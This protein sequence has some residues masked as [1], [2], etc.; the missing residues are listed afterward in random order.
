MNANKHANASEIVVEVR[1]NKGSL[2]VSVVDD[3]VGF[4]LKSAKGKGLGIHI[5]QSRARSIG[6]R[7]VLKSS[8]SGGACVMCLLPLVSKNQPDTSGGNLA[9]SVLKHPPQAHNLPIH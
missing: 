3:G 7:L 5:M 8:P 1:R 4:S 2:L 9:K 6:A